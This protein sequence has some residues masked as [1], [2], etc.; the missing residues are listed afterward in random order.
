MTLA[1]G[2]E[3]VDPA[4]VICALAEGRLSASEY[5]S[6]ARRWEPEG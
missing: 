5:Q 6:R 3:A 2:S 1:R 4:A